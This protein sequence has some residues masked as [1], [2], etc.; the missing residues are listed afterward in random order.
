[1]VCCRGFRFEGSKEGSLDI[2]GFKVFGVLRVFR[3]EVVRRVSS[4]RLELGW[5]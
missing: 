3:V 4:Y 2:Y 5:G 1:M